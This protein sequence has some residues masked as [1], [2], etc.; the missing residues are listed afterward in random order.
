MLPTRKKNCEVVEETVIHFSV[1]AHSLYCNTFSQEMKI[2]QFLKKVIELVSDMESEMREHS[3]ASSGGR[4][5]DKG[6]FTH[7]GILQQNPENKSWSTA[8]RDISL[9]RF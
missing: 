9:E 1:N 4:L 5:L 7:T 2:D 3:P 8:E 6:Y